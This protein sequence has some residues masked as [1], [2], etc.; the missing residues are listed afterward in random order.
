MRKA[1]DS[2]TQNWN[3]NLD[4]LKLHIRSIVHQKGSSPC[5]PVSPPQ[6]GSDVDLHAYARRDNKHRKRPRPQ[7]TS[8]CDASV[9]QEQLS[10]RGAMS[11]LSQVTRCGRR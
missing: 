3:K 5:T 6:Q 7:V 11:S 2:E 9:G 1:Q 8:P 10:H 4:V